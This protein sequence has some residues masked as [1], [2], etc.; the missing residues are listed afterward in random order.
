MLGLAAHISTKAYTAY[1]EWANRSH[2][3]PSSRKGKRRICPE[4]WLFTI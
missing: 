2:G 1:A 3:S 4:A